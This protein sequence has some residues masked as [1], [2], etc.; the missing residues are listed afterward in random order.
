MLA[1]GRDFRSMA[2]LRKRTANLFLNFIETPEHN[3]E[4]LRYSV[5][6][7]ANA[8]REREREM[9]RAARETRIRASQESR[10]VF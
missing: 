6:A 2:G 3:P 9:E 5:K 7:L 4:A 1:R 8:E 10:G